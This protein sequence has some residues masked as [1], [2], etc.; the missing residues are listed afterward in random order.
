MSLLWS[1]RSAVIVTL[2]VGL[3]L[4]ASPWMGVSQGIETRYAEVQAL[5]AAGEFEAADRILDDLL[6]HRPQNPILWYAKGVIAYRRGNLEVAVIDLLNSRENLGELSPEAGGIRGALQIKLAD[7]LGFLHMKLGQPAK[8]LSF[9]EDSTSEYGLY[10]RGTIHQELGQFEPALEN[11]VKLSAI[12]KEEHRAVPYNLGLLYYRQ[13][14]FDRALEQLK[15]V[16]DDSRPEVLLGIAGSYEGLG[17]LNSAASYYARLLRR[18]DLPEDVVIE[19]RYRLASARIKAGEIDQGIRELERLLRIDPD[20]LQGQLAIAFAHIQNGS[21][22]EARR[23]LNRLD[24]LS[25]EMVGVVHYGRGLIEAGLE[26][27]RQAIVAY[28]TAETNGFRS[29]DLLVNLGRA[30]LEIGEL[31]KANQIFDQAL[32]MDASQ[33]LLAI[34]DAEVQFQKANALYSV[35]NMS[36]ALDFYHQALDGGLRIPALHFNLGNVY[37]RIGDYESAIVQYQTSLNLN[38]FQQLAL[39]NMGMA[40]YHFGDKERAIREFERIGRMW[41]DSEI[42]KRADRIIEMIGLEMELEPEG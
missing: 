11:F 17:N 19:A 12:F 9:L 37:F 5:F 7:I 36:G 40:Y 15:Q 14:Q 26:N 33:D 13:R 24:Q 30:Y 28:L 35:G 31:A 8:A 3:V 20:H 1:R 29:R 21:F 25:L 16:E 10:L 42:T 32:S 6:N 34:S 18:G 2:S 39:Y 23:Y 27:P 38:I 4:I 41:P 22:Q